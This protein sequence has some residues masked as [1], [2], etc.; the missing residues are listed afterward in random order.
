MEIFIANL[1][2]NCE[3]FFHLVKCSIG[4]NRALSNHHHKAADG[5]VMRYV[6]H[7]IDALQSKAQLFAISFDRCLFSLYLVFEF[8][9]LL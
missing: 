2:H 1:F 3:F 9:Y 5:A 8:V 7:L 6:T 4:S